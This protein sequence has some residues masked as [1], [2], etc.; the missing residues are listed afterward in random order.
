MLTEEDDTDR[1]AVYGN[2]FRDLLVTPS[3]A[4][5]LLF[6]FHGCA[7]ER[8]EHEKQ[9]KDL[10]ESKT[11]HYHQHHVTE[12]VLSRFIRVGRLPPLSAKYVTIKRE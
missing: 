1:P 9:F 3:L 4:S 11:R 2:F 5:M 10:R 12:V 6:H 8:D 7:A